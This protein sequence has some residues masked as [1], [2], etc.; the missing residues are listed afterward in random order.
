MGVIVAKPPVEVEVFAE[1]TEAENV[2]AETQLAGYVRS[3]WERAKFAKQP[4]QDRLL[5]CERQRRGVY[6]PEKAVEIQATGGSDIYMMLTD[7]KCHA[8]ASWI[9][10]V[11]LGASDRQFD[12]VPS[13]E[14]QI[15]P[16]VQAGIVDMVTQ[17]AQAFVQAGAQLHPEAYRTRIEAVHDQVMMK[18]REEAKDAARR[19]GDKIEDQMDQGKFDR[20]L[21]DFIDDYVTYPC[22]IFKGPTVKRRRRLSWGPDFTPVVVTDMTREFERVSP[23][24]IYPSPNSSG[25]QT[26]YI[27]Q[28]H[29]IPRS[30]L[31]A[32]RGVPGYSTE[33]I[34]QVIERF[35]DVG[36]RNWL[37]G[38]QERD[39]LEGKPHSRMYSDGIIE[40]LEFWGS[41]SGEQ[42]KRYGVEDEIDEH[43]E[44]EANVWLIGPYV[45]KAIIN[46][47]PLGNRP[48]DI[49]QW[50][51][52]PGAFW[53]MALPETMRD[54][55]T[56]C[57]SS[58]RALA[59][60]M[61]IASGPQVDIAIDR[62]PD[63]EDITSMYP[64]KIWQTTSDRTGGGAPAVKFFQPEMKAG[65][66]M[67][68]YQQFSKQADEITGI[69]NYVYGNTSVSGAGRTAS[70]LSMLMDNAAKGIKNAVASIDMVVSAVVGRLYMHNMMYDPDIWVKGDFKVVSK[71]ALGLVHKE[72]IQM[73]RNEFLQ[74][75]ANPVDLQIIGVEGRSYLL[76]ELASSLQMDT[77]KIVPDV[78]VLK[79]KQQQQAE[80]QMAM[81]VMAAQ[82]QEA[83]PAP[84]GAP[85]PGP[86]VPVQ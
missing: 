85:A 7:I 25:P 54:I 74:A 23:F 79:F 20:A 6:D 78:E 46:P 55:Q 39:N 45:I 42:L 11:M 70:G 34:D 68:V 15:P 22:A 3:C 2:L 4:I 32:L 21:R 80:Q 58:A 41:V 30:E 17:E 61:S 63:G 65:E 38:D 59:N 27:I 31:Q 73:R 50:R 82:Q 60:N 86:E 33:A 10:D 64:W 62:L 77:D 49:A 24:D 8:A 29:R 19:M 9:K 44:Y 5:R 40:A 81:Q 66:L 84:E 52:I 57:N 36:F 51:E 26:G 35:G 43:K 69:P 16:E 28:R 83:L 56:M 47:D 37:M 67:T 71:G 72:Q 48:Y 75:T 13:R 18:L 76:R 14:P 53:G 12:L 1:G